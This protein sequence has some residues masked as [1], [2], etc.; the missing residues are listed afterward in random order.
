M[1]PQAISSY[2]E[3]LLKPFGEWQET[4]GY[5]E[6]KR[7]K[8]GISSLG[9]DDWEPWKEPEPWRSPLSKHR[10]L[11]DSFSWYD[12][13]L[14][15]ALVMIQGKGVRILT[16]EEEALWRQLSHELAVREAIAKENEEPERYNKG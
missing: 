15:H 14:A 12:S 3:S 10:D 6:R 16:F 1:M 2:I 4:L 13:G 8:N 7:S 9:Y 11:T 5:W